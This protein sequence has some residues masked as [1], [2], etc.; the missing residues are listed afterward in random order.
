[1]LLRSYKPI[2]FYSTQYTCTSRKAIAVHL[3]PLERLPLTSEANLELPTT[4]IFWSQCPIHQP[5][6]SINHPPCL[7]TSFSVLF[8]LAFPALQSYRA[9]TVH[10][11]SAIVISHTRSINWEARRI[12]YNY[13]WLHWMYWWFFSESAD[14]RVNER[15]GKQEVEI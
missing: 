4:P 3:L 8:A 13:Y 11:N 5:A 6:P 14:H 2:R 12:P 7:A 10:I 9:C 1:M 15:V